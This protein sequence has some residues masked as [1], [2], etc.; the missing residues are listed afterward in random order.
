MPTK[1]QPGV[2]KTV[3]LKPEGI[4]SSNPWGFVVLPKR[5]NGLLPRRGRIT[6]NV[7]VNGYSFQTMLEPDGKLSHWCRL[8]SRVLQEASIAIGDELEF[9]IE[10]LPAEPVPKPPKDFAKALKENPSA[11]RV[12]DS[13]TPIAQVDWIHWIESSKQT[14]TRE[15]RIERACEML[16]SGKKRVCCF[17]PSGYY[18]KALSAPKPASA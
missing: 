4:D 5:V 16:E 14:K 9:K 15:E 10:P 6:V 13:A 3:V 11:K 17:D 18:S 1:S 12:W 8:E 2:F 7:T